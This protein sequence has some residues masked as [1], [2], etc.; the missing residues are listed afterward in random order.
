MAAGGGLAGLACWLPRPGRWMNVVRVVLGMMMPW[1]IAVAA[2]PADGAHYSLPAS[3][4]GVFLI[5]TLLLVTGPGRYCWQNGTV[6]RGI[7]RSGGRG[8]RVCIRFGGE[9]SRRDRIHWQPPASEQAIACAPREQRRSLDDRRL[10]RD[11]QSQ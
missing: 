1:L 9:G 11:L 2:E 4:L 3:P 8:G 6:R 7:S 5:L 10:V